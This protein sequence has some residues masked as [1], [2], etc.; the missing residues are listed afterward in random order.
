MMS[1]QWPLADG[2]SESFGYV[3]HKRHVEKFTRS[4]TLG[5]LSAFWSGKDIAVDFDTPGLHIFFNVAMGPSSITR[6]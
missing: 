6:G 1:E 3:L 2:Y 4:G 5:G